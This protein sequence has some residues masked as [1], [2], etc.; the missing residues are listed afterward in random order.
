MTN[1]IRKKQILL[2]FF[3]RSMIIKVTFFCSV[4]LFSFCFFFLYFVRNLMKDLFLLPPLLHFFLPF[5]RI[6]EKKN[7][8]FVRK[9]IFLLSSRTL[10]FVLSLSQNMIDNNHPI[11]ISVDYYRQVLIT[12]NR[13][14][15]TIT[16]C[17]KK[18]RNVRLKEGRRRS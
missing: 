9:I 10:P 4:F 17:Y 16:C 14:F 6:R 7:L 15:L 13:F 1:F 8:Y 12:R 3:S 5:L 18:E 2:V 11:K